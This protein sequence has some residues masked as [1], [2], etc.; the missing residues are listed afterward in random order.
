MIFNTV[1]DDKQMQKAVISIDKR[2][3]NDL[4]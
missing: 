4:G 1:N 3:I 2:L